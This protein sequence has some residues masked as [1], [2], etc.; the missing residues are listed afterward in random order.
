[1]LV[2]EAER[3]YPQILEDFRRGKLR[4]RYDGGRTPLDEINVFPDREWLG[5]KYNYKYSSI[6]T[7]RGCPFKCDFCCVPTIQGRVYRERPPEDVWA[8]LEGTS[9]RGL[10]LAEDNF[11]GYTPRAQ[12]RCRRLFQ[13]WA[14]RDLDKKWFGF[15]SLNV[16]Q[17]PIVLEYMARSG[18]LGF[19]V[20]IESLDFDTLKSM[21]KSVNIGIAKRKNISMQEA[22]RESFR[23][24]HDKG[25]VVWGSVI[26]GSDFDTTDTFKVIADAVWETGMDVTTFGI[27]TPMWGT[28]AWNK[29]VKDGRIFRRNCPDDWYFYNSDHLVYR[30]KNLTLDQF[31]DGLTYVYDSIYSKEALRERFK[32]TLAATGDV[33]NSYFAYRIGLDWKIVFEAKL[34]ELHRLRDS[35]IYPHEARHGFVSVPHNLLERHPQHDKLRVMQRS[36]HR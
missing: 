20:G 6:V 34:F 4:P 5:A 22:Y 24:V 9:Y 11:Y 12:E 27:Y 23:N 7:T 26:F 14:E 29:L 28:E 8:E 35:G 25:M 32:K 10:M 2:G 3:I 13:G 1:V 30:L 21:H 17:D 15:T 18:C 16:T 19:L 33:V 31:I 36:V